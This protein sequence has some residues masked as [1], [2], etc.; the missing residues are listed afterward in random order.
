MRVL[1]T[2]SA[3][4]IGSELVA[5]FDERASSVIGIDN[6]MRAD[7]FGQEGSTRWNLRR[8]RETTRHYR[9]HEL[10]VRDRAGLAALFRDEGPFDLI[11]H[12]AAQPSHDLAASGVEL[13]GFLS[14]L[15][16]TQLSGGVY[17]VFGYKGKQVRDN[18]P[19]LRRGACGRGD[20]RRTALW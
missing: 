5:Y 20:R 8:I 3:G 17:R 7:F 4:L 6:D 10:D 9:H 12:S 16:K 1:V 15:V 2:G 18:H 13:R 19:Q 14:Y 11:I